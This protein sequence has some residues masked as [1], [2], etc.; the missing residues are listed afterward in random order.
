MLNF[1]YDVVNWQLKHGRHDLPWQVNRTPYGVWVSEIMLQQTQVG[2]A[3]KYFSQF[4][5]AFPDVMSLARSTEDEVLSLWSGL[6]YY[7]RARN[8]LKSARLL[9]EAHGGVVPSDYDILISLPGIGRSTAG[10]ILALAYEKKYPILDGNVK[11]VLAR[12]FRVDGPTN[13]SST[14][15]KLWALAEELMPNKHIDAYTQG[16]MGLGATVCVRRN[17]SCVSCPLQERCRAKIE[18]V[19]GTY[20]VANLKKEI[21]KKSIY[22]VVF[23]QGEMVLMIKNLGGG[24]W[25]GLLGFVD[26]EVFS[27]DILDRYADEFKLQVESTVH[28]D[29]FRHRLTHIDYVVHP[30][31][32]NVTR[33]CS[34]EERSGLK[35]INLNDQSQLPISV[36]VRKIFKLLR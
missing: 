23:L 9:V 16:L 28:L 2:T 18:D 5:T 13:V 7:S 32:V 12:V 35:W 36:P 15:R 17:P 34:K 20:P 22:M 33:R 19:V 11:R 1:S 10:A 4:M 6:G 3:I 14:M 27:A 31:R 29:N 25:P 26:S 30:I 21:A 8:L 24:L